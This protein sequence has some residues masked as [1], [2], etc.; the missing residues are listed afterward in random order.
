MIKK[1]GFDIDGC[2]MDYQQFISN[3]FLK[4]HMEI[5]GNP[6]QGRILFNKYDTDDMFPDCQNE[7]VIEAVHDSFDVYVREAPF[8][9]FV[10]PLFTELKRQ[11]REIHIVTA[12]TRDE[13]EKMK[14]LASITEARFRSERIPFDAIHIGLTDKVAIIKANGIELMVE[15]SSE[16][17]IPLSE[18]IPVFKVERPYNKL[19]FGSNIYSIHT[20]YPKLFIEKLE[21]VENHRNYLGVPMDLQDKPAIQMTLT[22][23]HCFLN[24][25]EFVSRVPVFVI[26]LSGEPIDDNLI[27]NITACR[28]SSTIINL[29]DIDKPLDEITDPIIRS[30]ITKYCGDTDISAKNEIDAKKYILRSKVIADIIG[31]AIALRQPCT[32]YGPQVLQLER[33]I[34]LEYEKYP[35]VFPNITENHR[36]ILRDAQYKK[37]CKIA[38]LL[39]DLDEISMNIRKL[40]IIAGTD[41]RRLPSYINRQYFSAEGIDT[42]ALLSNEKPYKLENLESAL[43][44]ETYLLGDC[45]LDTKDKAK[46]DMIIENINLTVRSTDTLLFLGDFDAKGHTEKSVIANFLRRITCKNVYMLVGNNDGFSIAE[47][48]EMG[49][50]G[51]SDV[52]RY[53][54]GDRDIVLSHCPVPVSNSE[55]NIHGHLH[56]GRSYWNIDWQNH[57]DIWNED[58]IPIK[59]RDAVAAWDAGLY[60][61][62]SVNV[63]YI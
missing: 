45:H 33:S 30:S 12:R 41:P 42:V 11:K 62:K 10:K 21:Y 51:V 18:I 44:D 28:R 38:H 16:N 34:L 27:T 17:I 39:E 14:E 24:E 25:K 20:L 4:L 59:I 26:P 8:E 35:F 52:V 60:R 47:Y 3:Q 1:I 13:V 7:A 29:Y 48:A 57:I 23:H 6:Y 19:L 32:I 37:D 58:F 61:A 5:A 50:L 2:L 15:D 31:C 55:L 36:R 43:S 46:T 54:D 9:K 49:M 56:G 53:K 22:A 40:K 63:N